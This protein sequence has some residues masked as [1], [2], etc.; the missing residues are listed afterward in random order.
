[1]TNVEKVPAARL[2]R[3]YGHRMSIEEYFRD[4]KSKRNGFAMRLNLI[5]DPRRLERMLLVLALAYI[6]LVAVGLEAL[7]K[8]GPH[9]WCSNSR[10]GECSLFTIGRTMLYYISPGKPSQ[11]NRLRTQLLKGNWG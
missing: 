7:K 10:K 3:I 5:R 2:T 9:W 1:M 11:L 8:F 6:L 4:Q